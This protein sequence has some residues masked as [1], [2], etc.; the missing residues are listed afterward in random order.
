MAPLRGSKHCYYFKN[1][2]ISREE[3]K[4]NTEFFIV[5]GLDGEVF[6][7]G[8]LS[9]LAIHIHGSY[10]KPKQKTKTKNRQSA[11]VVNNLPTSFNDSA[12]KLLSCLKRQSEYKELQV[13]ATKAKG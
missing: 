11:E 2:E 8:L 10:A 9:A 6:L 1:Y 13:L 3:K 5:L 7:S 12:L 4:K